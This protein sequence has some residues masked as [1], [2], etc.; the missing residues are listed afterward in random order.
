V[1]E[2]VLIALPSPLTRVSEVRSTLLQSSLH[3]LRGRGHY[4]R[5]LE[6][7][8]PSERENILG[9][10][11]PVWLSLTTAM[12]HYD[13]CERLE[14][15]KQELMDVGENVGN[16]I[17][18]TFIGTIAK[19]GRTVGLTPWVPLAQFHRLWERLMQG[20]GVSITKL[21]PKEVRIEVRM[22]PLARYAYFRA[23]FCGVI[24]SGIK[25]GAGRA[26]GV[27]VVQTKSYEDSLVFRGSWV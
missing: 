22:L 11:A 21:G 5:Y 3:T 27:R 19:K 20:G 6:L 7:I 9:T 14:L 24:A 1:S 15:D 12:H 16:R 4:E 17:Q 2:E 23:A 26:V 13:A 25:L 8:D 18:G 10:L